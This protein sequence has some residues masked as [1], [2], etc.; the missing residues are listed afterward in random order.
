MICWG[1][2]M[3]AMLA[4]IPCL[5][6]VKVEFDKKIDFTRYKTYQWYP[7]RILKKTGI[8]E[9]DDVVAPLIKTAVNRELARRNLMEV[10]SGGDLQV[11]TWALS[12]SIPNIDA[13]IYAGGA[14][15][16]AGSMID[17]VQ[18]PVASMGRYNK[19]G[20]VVVNLI[21]AA[22]KKSAWAALATSSYSDV[23]NLG[24]TIDK[25]VGQMF[26]KYPLKP[27]DGS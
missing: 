5:A 7:P 8:S 14:R 20:T 2:F 21:D 13:L 26:N 22:T 25:A 15:L 3:S 12:E 18:A 23:Y 27:R 4:A 11:S 16:P 9:N 17:P 6:K 1:L 19:E 10:A 24:P